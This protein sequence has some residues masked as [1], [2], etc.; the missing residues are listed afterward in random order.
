MTT[1]FKKKGSTKARACD[2]RGKRERPWASATA[3]SGK[4][5]VVDD[6]TAD[7]SKKPENS[8]TSLSLTAQP[9]KFNHDIVCASSTEAVRKRGYFL[10]TAV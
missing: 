10:I 1:G 7:F 4:P 8:K 2:V 6:V 5:N 9:K 3:E